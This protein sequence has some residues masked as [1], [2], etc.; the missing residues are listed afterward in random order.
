MTWVTHYYFTL[1]LLCSELLGARPHARHIGQHQL[2]GHLPAS[3]PRWL[4]TL[5]PE[6]ESQVRQVA[7]DRVR[8]ALGSA[9]QLVG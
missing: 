4:A 3:W 2:D 6:S 9:N 8:G 7:P 1:R 5:S